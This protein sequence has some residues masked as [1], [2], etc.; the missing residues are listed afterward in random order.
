MGGWPLSKTERLSAQ[1]SG[2]HWEWA[3]PGKLLGC[4]SGGLRV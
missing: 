1:T 3:G 2:G 4:E